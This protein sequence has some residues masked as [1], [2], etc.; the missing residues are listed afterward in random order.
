[1]D[2]SQNEPEFVTASEVADYVFCKHS[3]HLRRSGAQVT[4]RTQSSMNAGVE[5]QDRKDCLVPVAIE[6]QARA[7]RANTTAWIATLLAMAGIIL[8]ELYSLSHR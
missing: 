7:K 6:R 5:W 1:L 4:Q 8:W 2:V 3:W